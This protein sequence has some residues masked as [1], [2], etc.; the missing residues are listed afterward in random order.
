MCEYKI[1]KTALDKILSY[2]DCF[3]FEMGGAIGVKDNVITMFYPLENEDT[4]GAC[5]VPS[6]TSLNEANDYFGKSGTDFGGIIHSH[7]ISKFGSGMNSPSKNDK[8]FYANFIK[9]NKQFEKL[10]VPIITLKEG[11]KDIAWYI[12][13]NSELSELDIQ[14]I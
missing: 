8:E 7:P 11:Q 5:F 2:F 1:T 12:Y 3:T 6:L 4:T 13:E 10:I 14:I 9:S